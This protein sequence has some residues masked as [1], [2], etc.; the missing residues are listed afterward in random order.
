VKTAVYDRKIQQHLK[1]FWLD[2][3]V[4]VV[5]MKVKALMLI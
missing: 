4:S 5:K 2:E 1:E 3:K